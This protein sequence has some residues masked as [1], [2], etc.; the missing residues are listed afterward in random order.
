MDRIA[1]LLD[2]SFVAALDARVIDD[3][4][5]MK[6]ECNDVENA[7]SYLRRLAQ[8]RIEIL[9]AEKARRERGGSV[10]D[11]VADLPRILSAESGRSTVT[12]TRVSSADPP[13]LQL[14]WPDGREKLVADSTLANLPVLPLDEL[15]DSLGRLRGF[16]H[17]L[18]GLRKD[19]HGVI[20]AL[21]REITARQVAGTAG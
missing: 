13:S 12:T 9:E 6:T 20:D 1:R 5:E 21:E 2:P 18:S 15:V 19:M 10:G 14:R 8:A 16:E 3:L 7:L 4:R 17:E 11:L